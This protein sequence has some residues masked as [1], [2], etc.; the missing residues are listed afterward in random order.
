MSSPQQSYNT[1]GSRNDR[2]FARGR[3]QWAGMS[4]DEIL[5]VL[6]TMEPGRAG[7]DVNTILQAIESVRRAAE[8][9]HAMFGDG[10]LGQASD[11]ALEA[12]R[13]LSADLAT[14]S[15][16]AGQIGDAL[17]GATGI[18]DLTGRLRGRPVRSGM[19]WPARRASSG[20]LAGRRGGCVSCSSSSVT[21]P[22]TRRLSGMRSTGR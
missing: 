7:G 19:R 14:T 11:A 10:M 15:E 17:A 1:Y 4:I 20:R 6:S 3:T 21:I 9:M 13:S 18:P 8:R 5:N 12:G 2:A 22:R 16:T